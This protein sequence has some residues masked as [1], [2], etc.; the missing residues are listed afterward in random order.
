MK[1]NEIVN[2]IT[3]KVIPIDN[4]RTFKNSYFY[5]YAKGGYDV[6]NSKATWFVDP[7][8]IEP[9][10][11]LEKMLTYNIAFSAEVVLLMRNYLYKHSKAKPEK[12]NALIQL[13]F[14]VTSCAA[15]RCANK[16]LY[17][18][19]VP[20]PPIKP[21]KEHK[22]KRSHWYHD[23]KTGDAHMYHENEVPEGWERGTGKHWHL[24]PK[25]GTTEC[26]SD[27]V[28]AQKGWDQINE[29]HENTSAKLRAMLEQLKQITQQKDIQ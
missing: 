4:T 8:L 12:I 9:G 13:M 10:S 1:Q 20:M 14:D 29:E 2:T 23:P 15:V 28:L 21:K 19:P 5:G 6:D 24:N 27:A 22:M 3:D 26:I 11:E 18:K 17:T 25:T 7:N 16:M